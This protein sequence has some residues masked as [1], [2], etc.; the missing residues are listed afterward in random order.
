L[1][2]GGSADA[3]RGLP[4]AAGGEWTFGFG[5]A[6]TPVGSALAASAASSARSFAGA[7]GAPGAAG[8]SGAAAES[9][10][11]AG[12][13]AACAVA[14]SVGRLVAE[15]AFATVSGFGANVPAACSAT[16]GGAAPL[17]ESLLANQLRA[18]AMKP[19][20]ASG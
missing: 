10:D 7:D 11:A 3:T 1:R 2:D 12:E 15:L 19:P 5:A 14:T 13:D 4:L 18:P 6:G 16:A 8:E 17:P 20:V 9:D